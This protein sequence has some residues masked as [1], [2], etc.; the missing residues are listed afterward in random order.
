MTSINKTVEM[1]WVDGYQIEVVNQQIILA[2]EVYLSMRVVSVRLE[3]V[4]VKQRIHFQNTCNP[5]S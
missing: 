2:P 4:L 1:I 3:V 5:G